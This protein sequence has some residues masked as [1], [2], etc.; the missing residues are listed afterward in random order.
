MI[1]HGSVFRLI[2]SDVSSFLVLSAVLPKL[3]FGKLHLTLAKLYFKLKTSKHNLE[4]ELVMNMQV[5]TN[6]N[7]Q[8]LAGHC[9]TKQK[10]SFV[11]ASGQGFK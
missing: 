2:L 7:M 1:I 5:L 11:S 4:L 6:M 9:S 8:A 3:T 10:S